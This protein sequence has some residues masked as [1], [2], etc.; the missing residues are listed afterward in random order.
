[1]KLPN[2]MHIDEAEKQGFTIDNH[3]AGRPFAYKGERFAPTESHECFT[4]LESELIRRTEHIYRNEHQNV[5][6]KKECSCND[7]TRIEIYCPVHG[8]ELADPA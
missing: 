8:G 1:M 3:A 6:W 4:E 2:Y 7:F 5:P